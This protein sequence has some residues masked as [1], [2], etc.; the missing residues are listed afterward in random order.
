MDFNFDDQMKK[1]KNAFMT[2]NQKDIIY[3]EHLLPLKT[4]ISQIL[5]YDSES[6]LVF[7][8]Q[9]NELARNG[10]NLG[11]DIVSQ[12][13]DLEN[14]IREY[15]ENKGKERLY[16]EQSKTLVKQL[17]DLQQNADELSLQDFEN[18]FLN[19]KEIYNRNLERY[20]YSDRDAIEQNIS[21]AQ[22]K[23]IIKKVQKGALDL[24]NEISKD[25]EERLAV[26]INSIIYNLMQSD[27]PSIQDIVNEIKY[28]MIERTDAVYDPE[29]WRLLD[30]AQRNELRPQRLEKI[31]SN[32]QQPIN[33]NSNQAIALATIQNKK[34]KF[35]LPNFGQIFQKTLKIGDQRMK[36]STSVQLGDMIIKTKDLANIDMDWLAKQ[37]P[38][39]MLAEIEEKK[40][41]QE[42][43]KTKARFKPDSKTLIYDAFE[44]KA[45]SYKEYYFYNENGTK[46]HVTI[47]NYY[48]SNYYKL[49]SEYGDA[50]ETTYNRLSALFDND[51]IINYAE[52]IDKITNSNLRQK[53]LDELGVFVEKQVVRGDV[54]KEKYI[55]SSEYNELMQKLPI[56]SNLLNSYNEVKKEVERTKLD[57]RSAEQKRREEFYKKSEFRRDMMVKIDEIDK[58]QTEGRDQLLAENLNAIQQENE[59]QEEINGNNGDGTEYRGG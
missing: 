25:D 45:N 14:K 33:T 6:A 26:A 22:A 38:E 48:W 30:A 43:K 52:L 4:K 20:S 50:I 56:Y 55:G 51:I 15:E 34:G 28:K 54:N 39:E 44:K 8:Q 23:L 47:G 49:E 19:V 13:V 21:I 10:E 41:E 46:L 42:R 35:K 53:L 16:N 37:V 17:E 12:I 31:E 1:D 32:L 18:E 29:I 9:Y 57:F 40:I 2:Q 7:L 11:Q 36:L 59:K 58:R 24:Y 27:N 3:K 5:L